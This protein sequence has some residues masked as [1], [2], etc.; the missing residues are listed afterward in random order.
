M[1]NDLHN[2]CYQIESL[3]NRHSIV[4]WSGDPYV[5]LYLL[6]W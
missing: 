4:K 6:L 1:I 2:V 3:E 5:V